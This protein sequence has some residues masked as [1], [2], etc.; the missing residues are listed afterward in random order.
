MVSMTLTIFSYLRYLYQ[1]RFKKMW[2]TA[3]IV[4]V[5]IVGCIIASAPIMY[6]LFGKE[7]PC[8]QTNW[9]KL[10][11]WFKEKFSSKRTDLLED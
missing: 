11:K 5:V 7:G 8:G 2:T 1:K 6:H 3:E 9:Q 10:V 4:A